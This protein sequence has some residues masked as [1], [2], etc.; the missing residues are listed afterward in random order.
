MRPCASRS[1]RF[2]A[3]AETL[4]TWDE[5]QKAVPFAHFEG[6]PEMPITGFSIDTRSLQSGNVFV[7]LKDQRDGH[8][9]VPTAFKAGAAAALVEGNYQRQP[10]DRLL[11][12]CDLGEHRANNP[13][14]AKEVGS[15]VLCALQWVGD[16]ARNRLSDDARV[17]AV[18]GSAGKT[19]TKEMLRAC[20]S[21]LGKVHASE[22]SF[23][24]HWGVPLTL[25]N[26]PRDTRYGV[27]EIGMNHE[28]EIAQL[29]P[30]VHPHAA[31]VTTVEAVHLEHF[32]SVDAI[33]DAKAEIFQ[34]LVSGGAAIIN[35]DNPHY[36]R[37]RVHA[38]VQAARIVSFGLHPDADVRAERLVAEETG[39]DITVRVAGRA[40]D[41]R[42]AIPGKHIAQNSLAVVAALDS[43][44]AD[45]EEALKALASL[46]PPP[47][48]GARDLLPVPGG[49]ILLLDESYN[50]NPASMRASLATLAT[51][52]RDKFPRRIA[53]LGDMLE[54]GPSAPELHSGLL[55]AVIAAGVDQL[56]ACGPHMKGL[57][58]AAS[59]AIKGGY[60]ETAQDLEGLVASALRAGD[61]VMI[62][63][64]N[65]MRLGPLAASLRK[66]A[67][68]G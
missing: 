58:A 13:Q 64:S 14:L 3:V 5:L 36:D 66:L 57:Y 46:A 22:K 11:I 21:R 8:E 15:D 32:A 25:A 41:Y 23:N 38:Q 44:G 55:E 67:A 56:F 7:A 48:R 4:W 49:Q 52:S 53:V 65:G 28:G 29:V 27:F 35:R 31:I 33:A 61:A 63:G 51:V 50:A 40:I 62:K 19:G 16:T 34:G 6:T 39:S 20:L 2:A 10:G 9:F 37:L 60:A 54:L 12:Y 59:P 43:I 18:T 17:I 24:N 47:G 1:K 30:W 26:M 68:A 42:L 45:L